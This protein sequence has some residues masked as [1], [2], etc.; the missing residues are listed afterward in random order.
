MRSILNLFSRLDVIIAILAVFVIITTFYVYTQKT[1]VEGFYPV[2]A[3]RINM[4]EV[5]KRRY[6]PY[7][8]IQNP[9]K[10]SSIPSGPAGDPVLNK[11]LGS[12]SY[13]GSPTQI[14]AGLVNSTPSSFR[15]P[16][17]QTQLISRIKMCE[18]VKTWD[19]SKL[20]DPEFEQNCGI[21][22]MDG[23]DHLGN[24]H[25]GGLYIDPMQRPTDNSPAIPTVGSCKG[26]FLISRPQCDIEKDRD[27]CSRYTNFD[28]QD[29]SDKCGLCIYNDKMLYIGNR[30]SLESNYSLIKKPVIFKTNLKF[31][32][33]HPIDAKIEVLGMINGQWKKIE[34]GSFIQ[35][36]PVYMISIEGHEN[37][38]FKIRISHPEYEP[39]NWSKADIEKINSM[40]N[41]K[42]V[43]FVRAQYGPFL[44][45]YL[46][47]DPRA[48]DVTDYVKKNFKVND[49][50]K[51][52]IQASNDGLGGDPTPGI[53]K[54]LRLVYSD[55]GTEFAYSFAPEGQVSKAVMT[56]NFDQLCPSGKI[57]SEAEKEI[58]ELD[59]EGK[60]IEGRIYTQGRNTG[61]PGA[62]NAWCVNKIK[63]KSRGL[64]GIWESVGRVPRT[65]PLDI[66]V[67]KINGYK[68][69]STG[70]EKM[71]TLSGSRTFKDILPGSKAPGIPGYLFWFWAKDKQ[72]ATVEFTVVIPATLRDP[73]SEEDIVN[74]PIGPLVSTKE[75]MIR[76]NS[77]AC[78]K[79]VDGKP[80]GPGTFT[81]K[82]IQSLFIASGCTKEGKA[83]PVDS[84]KFDK[85]TKDDTT[86]DNLEIDT[87]I[88]NLY[89]IH[90]VAVTGA[91][92]NGDTFEDRTIEKYNADCFGK[93]MKDPCDTP[94]KDVGPHTPQCLDY[95]FRNA[96]AA[97]EKV[98]G[99]YTGVK[100]RSSG[101]NTSE[102]N[103]VMYCQ[104]AGSMAP[105]GKN[106]KYNFDAITTAN[107]KGG[108]SAVKEFYRKIHY[109]ANYNRDVEPQKKA[110]KECYGVDINPPPKVCPKKTHGVCANTLLPSNISL[111]RGNQ[112]GIVKHN[113]NY[114]LSFKINLKATTG[115]WGSIF[116][117]TS[118]NNN[119]CNL[120][121]RSPGIWLF[122][123]ST[124]LHIILGDQEKGGNFEI[125]NSNINIPIGQE[126]LFT[127]ICK[128]PSV[129]VTLN[130]QEYSTTQPSKRA[131]GTFTV[132]SGDPWYEPAKAELREVCFTPL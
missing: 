13:E 67:T 131:G 103:P 111:L 74:C 128:G 40:V 122:P 130:E 20:S 48:K 71:G 123:G 96:G 101:T 17:E 81:E 57:P 34:G 106:G 85:L 42:R 45:D 41:P 83:Y 15:T 88:N 39:Y 1:K 21:C 114:K 25:V 89:D 6:N 78:E 80:Q 112:V 27:D 110:L 69:P 113:G 124:K 66:S 8:D 11:L 4:E 9:Q 127:L 43:K 22:S 26:K 62:G 119:C 91:N 90:S 94:F 125:P 73:T 86:G 53:Y 100:S 49:C 104:R 64:V 120:G 2:S 84:T 95:L 129:S 117:F 31:V 93:L 16:P 115:D 118:T 36:T 56:D 68:L 109:D 47:D 99:T 3:E 10:E 38:E 44:D 132:Y 87:I 23:Q 55:D 105:M 59:S 107:S 29:S 52:D 5:G 32:V 30:G 28:N 77:G 102:K 33:S 75:G 116:H 60:P 14:L 61:Y 19:C 126:S 98:G 7:A 65:V 35:N 63:T 108:I 46:K 12:L 18:T 70:P 121:D 97:N 92:A 50:G 37:Q 51:V 24:P 54:Q 72:L 76:L 82:C 58:C 79:L